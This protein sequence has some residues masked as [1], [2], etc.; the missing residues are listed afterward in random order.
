MNIRTVTI[1]GANGTLGCN[2][3]GILASFGN[4]SVSMATNYAF[5]VW[6]E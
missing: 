3:P 2:M 5:I 6:R 4:I 1:V